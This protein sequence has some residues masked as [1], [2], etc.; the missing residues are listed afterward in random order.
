MVLI[1]TVLLFAASSVTWLFQ[2]F[3]DFVL[4]PAHI[5]SEWAYATTIAFSITLST[6]MF[7]FGYRYVPHRRP[8]VWTAVVGALLAAVLWEVAK[9]LFRLYIRKVGVYDQIY[10]PLGVLVAFVMFVY[11]SAIV[12]V[13]GAAYVASLDSRAR[14]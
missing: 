13:F 5:A 7:Y 10:G 8:R 9:Q 4:R 2:W 3:Q 14:R 11:Y 12:F 1:L 6:M